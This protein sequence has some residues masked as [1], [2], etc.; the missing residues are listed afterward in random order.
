MNYQPVVE[1][2]RGELVESIHYGAGVVADREGHIHAWWGDVDAAPFMRSSSKPLQGLVVLESG[3]VEAYGLTSKEIAIICSSHSGTDEHVETVTSIQEKIG[4]TEADMMCGVH[5]PLD[6]E[7]ARRLWRDGLKPTPRRHNCSGKHSGMLALAKHIGA[8]LENYVDRE[9]PVQRLMLEAVASMCEIEPGEVQL[10]IDGCS[11]PTFAV[12]LR[13]A[14]PAFARLMDPSGLAP[15]RAKACRDV[16]AAMTSNPM[17][18]AGPGRFDT[19]FMEVTGG[20][21]LSKCGAEGY[22]AVGIPS[23][24]V[25]PHSP[26]LGLV[27]K[28]ADGGYRTEAGTAVVLIVLE[29]LGAISSEESQALAEFGPQALTNAR[30][31]VIGR[32]RVCLDLKRGG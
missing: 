13:V 4:V 8:T 30:G 25:G 7:T 2:T 28:I 14:A 6:V 20:R 32:S 19:R 27:A 31:L 22:Q 23:G 5:E 24:M 21:I 29:I 16:V 12:P 26:A 17:M 11:V 9:H 1:Y 15:E 3:A 10:G 18:V